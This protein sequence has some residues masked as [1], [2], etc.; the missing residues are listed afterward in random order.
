MSKQFLGKEAVPIYGWTEGVPVD[1]KAVDQLRNV[2]RMPFIHHH[3]AVMPDVHWGMGA[4][5]G[6]VIPTV[7]AIIPA[8]VGVDIGCGMMA[9][10]TGLVASDLPDN[11]FAMRSDIEAAVPHGRTDNGGPN[12]RGAWGEPSP[13]ADW[14]FSTKL[15][16]R[17]QA[18]VAKHPD[19][20]KRA[21]RAPHHLGTLG[22]GNHF[23]ELCLDENQAVWVMLHSGSRG[24]G[25]KIG[26]YFIERAKEE[27]RR[28]FVN[29]PDIDLAY[30]PE[31]S[32]LFDDYVEALHWAQVFAQA[33]R[34][35]MMR[36]VLAVLDRHFPGKLGNVDEVAVNCH[37]NYVAKERHFGKNV[38][39][40][41]KG[42]VRARE[43]DLGI[44]PGS[45]GA[46]SYIVRGK[47]NQEAYCSCSHGAGRVMSRGEAVKKISLE[48]H[49]KATDGIECRKDAAVLDESPA[50][51]KPIEAVMAAQQDLVEIVYELRQV[52]CVK[53]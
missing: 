50:A 36:S 48:E 30:L 40:T 8:A 41:R 14:T 7:G 18:I 44:I 51:Y 23:I 32:A 42:A 39:L 9:V 46:R 22:T 15:M 25:N 52:I 20:E 19:L 13:D 24:I 5:V 16:E 3:V 12:D 2:A 29:L 38:W 28:W 34:E 49:A 35:V 11:L 43:G 27:M 10:R 17:L 33:N 21:N 53:G 47:G 26:T 37:H 31:G 6:S 1:Q 4:T 45:M